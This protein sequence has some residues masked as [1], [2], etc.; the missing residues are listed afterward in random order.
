ML[1]NDKARFNNWKDLVTNAE[2]YGIARER[3]G[4]A[5]KAEVDY[6]E[7][8]GQQVGG[9]G[10]RAA[11]FMFSA[12]FAATRALDRSLTKTSLIRNQ[13]VNDAV[14]DILTKRGTSCVQ[15]SVLSRRR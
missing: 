5:Y 6:T 12:P 13:A 11:E 2:K 1:M 3:A 10:R 8:L 15:Q 7:D 14:V 4:T 9:F